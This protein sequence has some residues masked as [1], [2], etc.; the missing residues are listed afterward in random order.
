MTMTNNLNPQKDLRMNRLRK[1]NR[2]FTLVE[3]SFVLV[4]IGFIIG[5]VLTGR[6]IMTN[7]EIT[8]SA[9]A[10]QSF[11]AQF[12]TYVQN[13]GA[14]PGDDIN[15]KTRFPSAGLTDVGDGSGTLG[16]TFD[17]TTASAESRLAWAEL[18]AASLVKSQGGTTASTVQPANPF[19]GIYGF[20]NGAF[21]GALVGNV[22]CMNS[23]PP[24]A[25]QAID[26]R[27]DDG[28][29]NSGTIRAMA[30][31]GKEGEATAGTVAASYGAASA[32]ILC[33]KM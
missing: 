7:A 12:Q 21:N 22:V 11:Q 25:A 15:A 20:Q 24:E 8:N 10:L 6:Q 31:S 3:L 9:N 30:Y 27:L 2:G 13:Y 26:A 1:N 5:G 19:N 17:S 33:A 32:Y 18:R 28:S 4:I 29:S 14:V 16:G 23:V